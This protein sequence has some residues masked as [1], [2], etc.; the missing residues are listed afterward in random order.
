MG[1]QFG[2]GIF[3]GGIFMPVPYFLRINSFNTLFAAPFPVAN[4]AGQ[5]LQPNGVVVPFLFQYTPTRPANG[6][7]ATHTVYN[8]NV[9]EDDF[10][11][12]LPAIGTLINLSI[13][14]TVAKPG[15]LYVQVILRPPT[16]PIGVTTKY[17]YLA[18]GFLYRGVGVTFPGTAQNS[19][20]PP[21]A[22]LPTE[23][24]V[25]VP[26]GKRPIFDFS[27]VPLFIVSHIKVSYVATAGNP[28]G[29][30]HFEIINPTGPIT[31]F[32]TNLGAIAAGAGTTIREGS[33]KEQTGGAFLYT[34]VVVDG[35][36]LN[37]TT[38]PITVSQLP[39]FLYGIF[40]AGSL[41]VQIGNAAGDVVMAAGD[42]YLL[43]WDEVNCPV[44][45]G[46]V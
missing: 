16:V 21:N 46:I 25:S 29:T 43:E 26:V 1:M 44:S 28:G 7:D 37:Q 18:N 41:Q 34:P 42:Q 10:E 19:Y 24:T 6:G 11:F 14:C 2:Y 15:Q 8:R 39:N 5:I 31:Q 22:L 40:G 17:I 4:I 33:A 38:G 12:L 20:L 30:C 32:T 23:Y 13:T 45:S 35:S 3:A 27:S 36:D 9:Q